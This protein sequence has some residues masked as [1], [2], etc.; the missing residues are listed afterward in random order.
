[1]DG[2]KA[3]WLMQAGKIRQL[4]G[5]VVLAYSV[6]E[7]SGSGSG[8]SGTSIEVDPVGGT[9]LNVHPEL[10]TRTDEAGWELRSI[11]TSALRR[12][13]LTASSGAWSID[14]DGMTSLVRD[15][16][17]RMKTMRLNVARGVAASDWVS[18]DAASA[19]RVVLCEGRHGMARWG[20]V[21]ASTLPVPRGT[22]ASSNDDRVAVTGAAIRSTLQSLTP[23]SIQ[24][25][26]AE[27]MALLAACQGEEEEEEEE[28]G[29][30]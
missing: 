26:T 1:M 6:E 22:D 4:G 21:L 17:R 7:G 25:S 28:E 3:G 27:R 13:D 29:P 20:H 16:L 24:W 10:R 18:H 12:E 8:A 30:G 9:N 2:I 23:V 15:V 19:A 11:V 14:G 5:K